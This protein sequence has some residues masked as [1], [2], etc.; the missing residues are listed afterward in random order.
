MVLVDDFSHFTMAFGLKAKSEAC[1]TIKEYVALVKA[2]FSVN[3]AVF[4]SDNG[5]EFV[6]AELMAFFKEQGIHCEFTVPYTPQQNGV[7]ERMNRTIIEKASCMLSEAK[8]PKNLWIEAVMCSVFLINRSPTK[9]LKK[10]QVPAEVWFK[11]KPDMSKIVVFG[12]I[13]YAKLPKKEWKFGDRVKK[14]IM[15]GY[16]DNGYRLYCPEIGKIVVRWSV[17]FDENASSSRNQYWGEDGWSEGERVSESAAIP[18]VESV[19]SP[20]ISVSDQ[21]DVDLVEGDDVGQPLRRSAR[22]RQTPGYLQDYVLDESSDYEALE[23]SAESNQLTDHTSVYSMYNESMSYLCESIPKD[24]TQIGQCN[25]RAAWEV[26]IKEELEALH[27]NETWIEVAKPANKKVLT[28][29]WVMTVKQDENGDVNR[30]KARLVVRGCEQKQGFDFVETYAPVAQMNTIRTVLSV[31][32]HKKMHIHQLDVKNAFLN[33]ELKEEIFMQPPEGLKVQEGNVLKLKKAL[34]GLKQ[35]PREWNCKFDCFVKTLGFCQCPSDDCLYVLR[36]GVNVL[37]LL[38]YVDDFLLVCDSL[39]WLEELKMKLTEKFRMRDLGEAKYFLGIK[40]DRTENSMFLSQRSYTEMVLTRFGMSECVSVNTPLEL[41]PDFNV[42]GPCIVGVKPYREVIGSLM[43]LSL[44]T[45]PDISVAVNHYSQ[46]QN[47]ASEIQW[48]GLK[49]ILRYLKGTLD[50]GLCYKG[51]EV[52]PIKCFVDADYANG[53]DRKSITGFLIEV[54]GDNVS[55]VTRKQS[56]ISLSTTEAEFIALAMSVSVL[57]WFKQ[58]L[59]DL[60][61]DTKARIPIMEDNQ[62]CIKYLENWT[63]KRMKHVDVKHKYVREL[64]LKGIIILVYVPTQDQKADVLTKSLSF[65]PFSKHRESLG[66]LKIDQ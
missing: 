57:L 63:Q 28:C 16:A 61:I 50:F 4:R 45:R 10:G 60:G 9:A 34:Y 49:R 43:Y 26:A 29:R 33:S 48:K 52:C 8:L 14:C 35:S 42:S 32:N 64:Y 18:R 30:H 47:N 46:F 19:Q 2:R 58:L 7:A 27:E 31:A 59:L 38:L 66:L 11:T 36:K 17:H 51:T 5:R 39:S 40:I 56:T 12:S 41:K 24:F 3:I 13:A 37:Y 62:S 23:C 22:N 25:D 55:W 20:G 54:F 15:V 44:T 6:N 1:A 21:S 53:P 65:M